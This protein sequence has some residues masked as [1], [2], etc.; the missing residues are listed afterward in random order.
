MPS[1]LRFR[2]ATAVAVLLAL[3]GAGSALAAG[4]GLVISQVYGGGG[5]AGAPLS[6][7]YV[8]LYNP[9]A[10][11][12]PLTG[13]SIQYASAAG[14][15]FFGAN[16]S[17]L[18]ELS[19]TIQAG[20]YFLVGESA[21][22]TGA[23]IPT[24]DLTDPTPINLSGSAGKVALV[25]GTTGL[26][27]NGS[28]TAACSAAA[29]ARI[30][31][32]VGYGSANFFEGAG[33]APTLSNSTA[34]IRNDGG[35]A[36]SNNNNLDFTAE[37]PN[38]RNSG[39]VPPPPPPPL[40][41]CNDDLETRIHTIQG[42]G[43]ASPVV[44]SIRVIE[45]VVVGDFQGST[46]LSG[47][48]VQEEDADADSDP[49]S[50]EGIF[51]FDPDAPALTAGDVVRVRGT[52]SEGFGLTQLTNVD[53]VDICSS[54]ASVTSSSL[55][56]PVPSFAS[57]EQFEGMLTTFG[58]ELTATETFTLGRFGEVSLS[59]DGRLYTP[60]QLVAP[61]A[62]A[63]ALQ[64]GER[65]SSDPA[66]R[67]QQRPE[68]ARGAVHR[69]RQHAADRGHRRRSDGRPQLRIRDI[70]RPAHDRRQLHAGEPTADRASGCRR[71]AQGRWRERAQLLHHPRRRRSPLR[72]DGRPRLPRREHRRGVHSAADEDH[73]RAEGRWTR[74][75]SA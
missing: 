48:F 64:G 30:V 57:L 31:D 4:G 28:T 18:T 53:A 20:K 71:L 13:L 43:S 24:A 14:T 22:A 38:P 23:A 16:S 66:R 29:L 44:G 32:L 12:V 36:D 46:S 70:S 51:A 25:T 54:G 10:T 27:C 67:Q 40:G 56:L 49:L 59:A 26:G 61:G 75:S 33:A 5:N 60:T 7:D 74:M 6:S 45:G 47:Y 62:A 34:A 2:L 37:T 41:A 52:V 1:Q 69:R 73:R 3:A 11:D 68:P 21:G 72:P 63:I 15:G 58:Q 19:G 17:Q 42:S 8:E 9:S 35:A 65:S 55:S 39:F 50:S